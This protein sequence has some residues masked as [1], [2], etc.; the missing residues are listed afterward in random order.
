MKKKQSS[1]KFVS[2]VLRFATSAC[3]VRGG[4]AHDDQQ[5]TA[6]YDARKTRGFIQPS[7]LLQ[8]TQW[9]IMMSKQWQIE[10]RANPTRAYPSRLLDRV[11]GGDVQHPGVLIPPGVTIPQP[12]ELVHNDCVIEGPQRSTSSAEVRI[13]SDGIEFPTHVVAF[14]ARQHSS[15][16]IVN[17]GNGM[18]TT[19]ASLCAI[20]IQVG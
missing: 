10:G 12:R 14:S 7:G 4:N 3:H 13:V 17:R 6:L 16:N 8:R 5:R 19:M 18:V 9:L 20:C 11:E 1:C 15:A 2:F